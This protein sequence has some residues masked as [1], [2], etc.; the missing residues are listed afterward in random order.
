MY[1]LISTYSLIKP[2]K[3]SNVSGGE[4]IDVLLSIKDIK[5]VYDRRE[6]W[7]AQIDTILDKG[8]HAET[9]SAATRLMEEHDYFQCSTSDYVLAYVAGFVARKATRFAK[10]TANGK[11][12][13]C[14]ECIAS[15]ERGKEDADSEAYK[16]IR[17]RTKG[18]LI[19]PSMILFN[20]INSLEQA[21]LKAV[22][23]SVINSDTIFEITKALEELAPLSLVG[24]ETHCMLFTHRVITFFLTTRMFFIAKQANKNDCIEKERTRE[25]RKLSKLSFAPDHS[26]DLELQNSN[27]PKISKRKRN[28]LKTD[29]RKPKKLKKTN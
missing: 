23:T 15:L 22:N 17:M 11:P 27:A 12:F 26:K 13:V 25:K 18:F 21:T 7:D 24:C 16:L 3:G 28:L 6:Q 1:K 10:Y 4:I 2:P 19:E 5:S 20:L 29:K 14:N 9:L 8:V